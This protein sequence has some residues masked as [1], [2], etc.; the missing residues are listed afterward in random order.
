MCSFLRRVLISIEQLIL[1]NLKNK[2]IVAFYLVRICLPKPALSAMIVGN[3][4]SA[5]AND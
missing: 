2:V 3:C 5:L 1:Q 4:L